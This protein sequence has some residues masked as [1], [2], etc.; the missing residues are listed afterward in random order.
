MKKL[1]IIKTVL[2]CML[3]FSANVISAQKKL[4]PPPSS[5]TIIG[6]IS[7]NVNDT[8]VY[9]ATPPIGVTIYAANWSVIGGTILSQN[10][11]SATIQ[12]TTAG[13][14]SITYNVTSSSAGTMQAIYSVTITAN[15]PAIPDTPSIQSQSCSSAILESNG[16]IPAEEMWYW[17][18]TTKKGTSTTYPATS[19]YTAIASGTYKLRAKNLAS[20]VWSPKSSLVTVTLGSIGGD[21]WYKDDDLD[22][23]GDPNDSQTFCS[24]PVS[25]NW[26]QNNN[27]ICP[28]E[29]SN[30][31]NGCRSS[32]SYSNENYI[33]TIIPQK[34][35]TDV[36][37]L[38]N[39]KDAIR[40][41]TYIDGLGRVKQT[42]DIMQSKTE[43]DIVTH[44][45]YDNLGRQTKEYLPYPESTGDGLI[46][47]NTL[48]K[49]NTYYYNNY[50]SDFPGQT[51]QT[52]NTYS[53][54]VVGDSPLARIYEQT[55]PG[56]VWKKGATM[57]AGGYSNGHTRKYAY[58]TN[59]ANVVKKFDVQLTASGNYF[60]PSLTGGTGYYNTGELVKEI[61][62]NENWKPSDGKNNTVEQYKDKMGRVLLKRTYSDVDINND[63]DISDTGEQ[64]V[65]HD[66]YYVYDRYNNLSFVIPPK[67]SAA[68][69]GITPSIL[70]ELCYQNIYDKRNRIIE[71]KTPGKDWEYVIYDDLNRPIL[72][73]DAYLRANN[74]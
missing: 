48:S 27:D 40:T 73:Q 71:K 61:G 21:L 22:G 60:I 70:S 7:A 53:E 23:K 26:V 59:A 43:K 49:T 66:T 36:S 31:A 74:K 32:Q 34:K 29:N 35:T 30:N 2:V 25:G 65:A 58:G 19:T 72:T 69:S 39:T 63:G 50:A 17:Q 13:L 1:Y 45:S 56:T 46:K 62:K 8:K 15:A 44:I 52:I 67:A 51:A 5:P 12:W 20:G 14:G 4:P 9:T 33:Y 41:I 37:T 47:S 38:T 16:T 57:L 42:I 55:A 18:G 54:K 68:V 28:G 24:P 6:A 10:M 3:L 11:S 64:E